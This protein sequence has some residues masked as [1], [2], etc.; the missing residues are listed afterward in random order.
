MLGSD[1]S[2]LAAITLQGEKEGLF[3]AK[4]L[5]D[6]VLLDLS[7]PKAFLYKGISAPRLE[8]GKSLMRGEYRWFAYAAQ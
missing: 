2:K 5:G 4:V 1:R 6:K 7:Q 8:L 3:C